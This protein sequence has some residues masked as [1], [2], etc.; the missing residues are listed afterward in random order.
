MAIKDNAGNKTTPRLVAKEYVVTRLH[1]LASDA[2]EYIPNRGDMTEKEQ[3]LVD[4]QIEK[5]IAR[6]VKLLSAP[7]KGEKTSEPETT[8]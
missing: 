3:K 2:K 4:E 6:C 7:E 5:V 1:G 8:E